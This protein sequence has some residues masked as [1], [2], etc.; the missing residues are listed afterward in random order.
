MC[1]ELLK[2]EGIVLTVKASSSFWATDHNESGPGYHDILDATFVDD[3]CVILVASSP[4]C[5]DR[6]IKILLRVIVNVFSVFALDINWGRGKT[7][8][9]L[10]YRGKDSTA[11]MEALRQEDGSLALN[12]P[13]GAKGKIVYC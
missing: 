9:L 12:N 3:Q 1:K 5:L 6:A 8:A 7:E 11:H 13:G 4:E 2:S 10:Q